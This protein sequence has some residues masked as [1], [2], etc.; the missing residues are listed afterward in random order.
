MANKGKK[1]Y[2]NGVIMRLFDDSDVIPD[3]FV[4][5]ALPKK[6]KSNYKT[7]HNKGKI[8]V[9]KDN[10]NFYISKDLIDNYLSKG[11]SIGPYYSDE[12]KEKHKQS[13]INTRKNKSKEQWLIDHD[14][15]SKAAKEMWANRSTE[16]IKS[17][18]KPGLDRMQHSSRGGSSKAEKDAYKILCDKFGENNVIWQYCTDV[19]YPYYC[20]FYIK[21][22]DLFIELNFHPSHGGEPF[23]ET[24]PEHIL[25][26]ERCINSP[27][28]WLD[29]TLIN[30]W[31][32]RDVEKLNCAINNKLNYKVYYTWE[33]FYYEYR[34]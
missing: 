6:D 9:N 12:S 26:K 8:V 20:D 23:D 3:G 4:L 34:V 28:T 7:P 25:I 10:K 16:Y 1:Y 29:E 30:I 15:R 19:R 17:I 11:Y 27:R 18:C 33:E 24:N 13:T 2:N 5:G 21:N 31:T 32:K 22:L 14:I